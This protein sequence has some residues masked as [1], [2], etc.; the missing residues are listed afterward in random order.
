MLFYI[1]FCFFQEED[2]KKLQKYDLEATAGAEEK[3]DNTEGELED[4]GASEDKKADAGPDDDTAAEPDP[5]DD[6]EK[7]ED[8]IKTADSAS[9]GKKGAIVTY[10]LSS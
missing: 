6:A 2:S 1:N 7:T 8:D 9:P 10:L 3:P 4:D 5:S